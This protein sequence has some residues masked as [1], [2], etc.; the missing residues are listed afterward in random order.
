MSDHRVKFV[1]GGEVGEANPVDT[2]IPRESPAA[3]IL[4]V[5]YPSG[6]F[7]EVERAVP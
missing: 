7:D 2:G 3:P 6:I 5:M 4:F 1:L